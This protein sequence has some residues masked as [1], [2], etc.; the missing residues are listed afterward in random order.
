MQ[1]ARRF[2]VSSLILILFLVQN[3]T[4]LFA[5]GR[6]PVRAMHGMVVSTSKYASEIGMQVL[7]D[8][9]NAIDAA[10]ATAFALAVTWPSAGNLGGGGFL[11][12]HSAEGAVT[13][14]DFREKAPLTASERMFLNSVGKIKN[15]S[16]H[17]GILAVGVPGTVAGLYATHKKYGHKNWKKLV[18]PAYKLAKEGIPLTWGLHDGFRYHKAEWLRYPSSAKIFLKAD[19]SLFE[20]GEK[21]VQRDLAAT[22]K[23]IMKKGRNGFYKG[24]TAQLIIDFMQKNGGLITQK[25]LDSYQAI[26]R[27]PVHG[28][29]R[30]YDI[31]AMGPPSSGGVALVEMLNILEGYDLAAMGE[32]SARYLHFLTEAMRRAFADRARYLGDPDFNTDM[33]I[34]KLIS[35]EYAA[36]LR[37]TI[38]ET[39]ASISDSTAFNDVYESPETTHFSVVDRFG[40]MVSLTY[41][42]EYP[43]GSR[44]VV[45]GAGFLLN[46]EMGDFNPVPGYTDSQGH[47]GTA[48]NLIAPEKRMLSSMSPT[49]VAKNGK[50]FMAVGSPGGRTIINTVLQV[51]LN[52]LELKMNIAEAVEAPRIH[53]QWLPDI[54]RMEDWGF[55]PDTKDLY[56]TYGHKT[57]VGWSQGATMGIVKNWENGLIYGA[58]DSRSSD[59]AAAGY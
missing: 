36:H 11:V 24:K 57:R 18:E 32:N 6:R 26:E 35:K 34:E 5:Q 42:L 8:G 15:E 59:G 16:N 54:T 10:V 4:T 7:K 50:P 1:N 19:S 31:Y 48:P 37:T 3:Q 29:F 53:H 14:F 51:I 43:Y 12:Y 25:D 47:I 45:D 13:T 52:V 27:K 41:T 22:L 21:W 55:S 44:M 17:E 46:N 49:I 40:N 23:R 58:A 33:P 56:E 39:K 2:S 20:P 30:G 9:G 28:T 38:A